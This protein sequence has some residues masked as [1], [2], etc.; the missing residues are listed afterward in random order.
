MKKTIS[1]SEWEIL[2]KLWDNGEMTIAQLEAAFK[3]TTGWSRHAIIS[4][5]KKM[6]AKNLVAYE[7][8]GR[9]KHYRAVPEKE[10]TVK[11]ESEAFL[12]RGFD[13]KIGL[14]CL[15]LWMTI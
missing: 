9:A 5:L 15:L 3:D 10:T 7:E 13:G 14:W 11:A 2:E 6:E 1:N 12:N 4:F 8:I